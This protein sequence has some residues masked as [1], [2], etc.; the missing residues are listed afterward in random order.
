M[1]RTRKRK[2]LGRSERHSAAW[3]KSLSVLVL[4][5]V[6]EVAFAQRSNR[7]VG[8][9][10]T[11]KRLSPELTRLVSRPGHAASAQTVKVI[12]RY[13]QTPGHSHFA[14]MQNIGGRLHTNLQVIRSAAFTIP[15][16]ALAAL[17]ADPEIV[18]VTIDH[19]LN[20]LDDYT[21]AAANVSAAWNAG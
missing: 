17:E 21:D 4:L 11:G 1:V 20:S 2:R 6:T 13:R 10:G 14:R 12:V 7:P 18:S 5:L 8:S 16:S 3:G 19:P 15:V 9:D